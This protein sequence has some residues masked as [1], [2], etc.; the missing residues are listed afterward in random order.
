MADVQPIE[1]G[2]P[3]QV[4]YGRGKTANCKSLSLRQKRKVVECMEVAAGN[5]STTTQKL[6][7]LENALRLCWP[8]I[9]EE[10]LDT[11]D[12]VMAVEI[13]SGVLAN[14]R[15]SPEQAKKSE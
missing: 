15:V 4:N 12:D 14:N 8:D 7:S 6:D 9:T 5:E 3:L 10:Q 2:E 13:V 11:I 1:P